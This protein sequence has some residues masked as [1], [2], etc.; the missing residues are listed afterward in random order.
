MHVKAPGPHHFSEFKDQDMQEAFD[1][2]CAKLSSD[3]TRFLLL[4]GWLL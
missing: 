2:V 4:I 3:F 1:R